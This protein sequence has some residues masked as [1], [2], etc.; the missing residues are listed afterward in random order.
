MP[1][2]DICR[3]SGV[4]RRGGIPAED[5]AAYGLTRPV[6]GAGETV[7]I[8]CDAQLPEFGFKGCSVTLNSSNARKVMS[9]S[10]LIPICGACERKLKESYPDK[11]T[12]VNKL[13]HRQKPPRRKPPGSGCKKK[14]KEQEADL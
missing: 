8:K 2:R 11:I 7:E 9:G 5:A 10:R 3:N 13:I 1:R 14:P 4:S 12:E 6:K